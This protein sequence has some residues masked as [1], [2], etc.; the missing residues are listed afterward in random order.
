M[1]GT[2]RCRTKVFEAGHK[3][4]AYDRCLSLTEIRVGNPERENISLHR[5]SVAWPVTWTGRFAP[6]SGE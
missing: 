5:C 4:L 3:M 2:Y 6:F 1:I